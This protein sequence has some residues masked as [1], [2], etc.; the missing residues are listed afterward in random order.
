MN[1]IHD[2]VR[3]H[4]VTRKGQCWQLCN[5]SKVIT[6]LLR[7]QGGSTT[8]TASS[9]YGIVR[10]PLCCY[11]LTSETSSVIHTPFVDPQ[12][13]LLP[14]LQTKLGPMTNSTKALGKK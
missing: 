11:E 12:L 14:L 2:S 6:F 10:A 3:L 9:V 13:V 8:T 7:F 4:A 1:K 5:D